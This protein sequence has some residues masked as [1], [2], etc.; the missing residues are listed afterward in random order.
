M[1]FGVD[2]MYLLYHRLYQVKI[3]E[4]Y[5]AAHSLSSKVIVVGEI[6][7]KDIIKSNKVFLS[8]FYYRLVFRRI[9][10]RAVDE[11][12]RIYDRRKKKVIIQE[13]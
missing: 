2:W 13:H 6:F 3:Q 1:E 4:V 9:R 11:Y 10:F 5:V 8:F 7:I 12:D